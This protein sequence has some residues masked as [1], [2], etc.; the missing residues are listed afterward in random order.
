MV[1]WHLERE[2][3]AIGAGV[4]GDDARRLPVD[5][6]V[7]QVVLDDVRGGQ[8]QAVG[9]HRAH[10]EPGVRS[11]AWRGRDRHGRDPIRRPARTRRERDA[12]CRGDHEALSHQRMLTQRATTERRPQ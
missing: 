9:D 6:H 3:G 5:L 2:H 11:V 12:E 7:A 10:P 8:H 4:E 1:D